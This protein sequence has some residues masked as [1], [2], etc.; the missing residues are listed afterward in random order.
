MKKI[1][2]LFFL[3]CVFLQNGFAQ[4]PDTLKPVV[5][6]S[7]FPIGAMRGA[8]ADTLSHMYGMNFNWM[9]FWS[10][11]TTAPFPIHS[12]LQRLDTSQHIPPLT[13]PFFWDASKT[14]KPKYVDTLQDFLIYQAAHCNDIRV[15]MPGTREFD[16]PLSTR[17]EN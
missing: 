8:V 12:K 6:Y 7:V 9:G 14:N 17:M 3:L 2:F 10:G 15:W 11:G 4:N 5:P 16:L 13:D 1:L